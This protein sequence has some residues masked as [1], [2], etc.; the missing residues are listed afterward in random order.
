MDAW[1]AAEKQTREAAGETEAAIAKAAANPV[2][3]PS[4]S[5][6]A[7]PSPLPKKAAFDPTA[8]VGTREGTTNEWC[9]ATCATGCPQFALEVCQCGEAD[10]QATE[11]AGALTPEAKEQ[12]EKRD[13][14]IAA[15]D[16]EMA[17]RDAE[18]AK[19]ADPNSAGV[20]GE[21]L[22]WTS[23]SEAAR[24][25]WLASR[26]AEIASRAGEAGSPAAAE[27]ERNKWL[28]SRDAEIASR[29]HPARK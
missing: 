2:G 12:L 29:L 28:E 18:I 6:A 1:N 10:T 17:N 7:S 8:C 4:P 23:A 16:A 22:D 27:A 13:S 19:R 20:N 11:A 14:V 26:D 15:R 24:D 3:L 21:A 9:Q 25:D 5:P